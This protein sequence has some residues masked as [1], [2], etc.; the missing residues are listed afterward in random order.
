M[1]P[2]IFTDKGT[3][4]SRNGRDGERAIFDALEKINDKK[5][6]ITNFFSNTRKM[7]GFVLHGQ[8]FDGEEIDF[9]CVTIYG[10]IVVECKGKTGHACTEL[11]YEGACD[12]LKRKV[13]KLVGSLGL[14]SD[15]PIF[16]VVAFPKLSRCSMHIVDEIH[17]LFKEDLNDLK[18]WLRRKKFILPENVTA[19]ISFENYVGVATAFLKQ[20]HSNI[21][22]G[23]KNRREF[24]KR[25]VS[26]CSDKLKTAFTT[27]YTT[28]QAELLKVTHCQDLWIP[29]AAGTGKTLVLK[30]QVK[31][32][33]ELYPDNEEK[34]IL[35]IT[36]NVPIKVD[37][38]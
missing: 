30:E 37:I 8:K 32:L 28:E 7:F 22:L 33:T 36:Y 27:F 18:K 21:T 29:G 2:L 14:P 17:V 26:D 16:K 25:V 10:L 13:P 4:G 35:V 6:L 19:P 5:G 1:I 12:Q 9:V 20:Y 3:R 24:K 34:K 31:F 38:K 11:K 15:I 23:F